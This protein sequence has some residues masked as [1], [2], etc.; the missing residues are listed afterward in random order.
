MQCHKR[1]YLNRFHKDLANPKVEQAQAIFQ[2]GTN[3]G[4]LTQQLFPGGVNAHGEEEWHSE[5]T[6]KRIAVILKTLTDSATKYI[7]E[8]KEAKAFLEALYIEETASIHERQNKL[9]KTITLSFSKGKPSIDTLENIA[10][11]CKGLRKS[12]DKLIITKAFKFD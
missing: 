7:L 4:L 11:L 12:Q 8:N 2:T 9:F 10:H 3:V 5:K 1:F 6:A